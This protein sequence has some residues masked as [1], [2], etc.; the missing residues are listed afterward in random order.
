MS[1]S[2]SCQA[3]H[4]CQRGSTTFGI[5]DVIALNCTSCQ[6]SLEIDDAFAGGVCRCQYCGTIQTVPAALKRGARPGVAATT[7]SAAAAALPRALYQKKAAPKP[8]AAAATGSTSSGGEAPGEL[9]APSA[10]PKT[11]RAAHPTAPPSPADRKRIWMIGLA[12]GGA[13]ALLIGVIAWI[14]S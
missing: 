8:P 2:S 1:P 7:A 11:L 4:G 6:K 12:I 9:A 10:P 5:P 14:A 3:G 13:A